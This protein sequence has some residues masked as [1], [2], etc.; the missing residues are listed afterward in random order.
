MPILNSLCWN[1]LRVFEA[2][3]RLQ[4]FTKAADELCVTQGAVS[5]QVRQLEQQLGVSL[6]I[7]QGRG[8]M[9]SPEGRR[10]AA[11]TSRV[12]AEISDEVRRIRRP[13]TDRQLVVSCCPS[14]AM[15]WLLPRLGRFSAAYPDI[16]VSLR[17]EFHALS[18]RELLAE[19]IDLAIRYDPWGYP[20]GFDEVLLEEY[21]LPVVAADKLAEGVQP[22]PE[23]YLKDQVWLLD[24]VGWAGADVHDEWRA[25]LK[26]KTL[27]E[28]KPRQEQ[29]FNLAQLAQQAAAQGRG[30]AMGR[31]ALVA[32]ALN[33]GQLKALWAP[34][35]PSPARY[36][37][38]THAER[39]RQAGVVQFCQWLKREIEEFKRSCQRHLADWLPE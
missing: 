16:E 27:P 35:V 31:M 2:A 29:I 32:D 26:A 21:L 20:I 15:Q 8:V 34:A 10:L 19:G 4:S 33:S 5:Q 39:R 11:L 30:V 13:E 36:V 12:V 37:L 28:V 23:K 24:G 7:R 9:L 17:A 25:W 18:P 1:G 3:A 14:F 6:F 38:L 22:T